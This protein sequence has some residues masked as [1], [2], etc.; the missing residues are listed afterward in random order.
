VTIRTEQELDELLSRPSEA[1][2][3]AMRTLGGDLIVLGAGGKMGPSLA[4]RARRAADEAGV[5]MRVIGVSRFTSGTE[6]KLL[7]GA[8]VE[9]IAADLLDDAQMAGLPGAPNVIYLATRKFGSSENAAMTWAMN[10]YLPAM[11]ARRYRDSRIALFSSGNVYPYVPVSSGGATEE[12]APDPVGEYGWS[13]LAR[14]RLFTYFSVAEGT[15]VSIL[16]LNYAVELRYGVLADIGR[17]VFERA[18]VDLSMGSVNVIWQGD[19]NSICLRSLAHASSPPWLMN[20]T[21][22]ETL[23]VRW[24]AERFGAHLGVTPQWRGA[25]GAAA[26]L[27]NAS[28]CVRAFGYPSVS[29]EQLIEWTASWI[30]A[31]GRS[32]NKPTHF[33]ATDGKF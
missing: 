18:P 26:L 14:E 6:R 8:G 33:E 5:K 29:A 31:G 22:P 19:A 24:I 32:L 7:D 9:T 30:G 11:A 10:A 3:E 28:R 12:T 17:R 13:A 23:S 21:G 27:N 4:I 20:L 1:D 25:E 16:R 2:C 15:P